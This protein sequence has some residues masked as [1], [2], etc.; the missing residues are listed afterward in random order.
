M[1]NLWWT[2]KFL[3]HFKRPAKGPVQYVGEREKDKDG[4]DGCCYKFIVMIS[5]LL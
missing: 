4:V 2:H 5:V 3:L 1:C